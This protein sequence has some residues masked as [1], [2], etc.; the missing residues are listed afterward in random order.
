M[1]HIGCSSEAVSGNVVE[2]HIGE[3]HTITSSMEIV[4]HTFEVGWEALGGPE[5]LKWD[6]SYPIKTQIFLPSK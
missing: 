6:Y 4:L 5:I 2:Y 3:F 1:R